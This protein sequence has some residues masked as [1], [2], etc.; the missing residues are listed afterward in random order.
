MMCHGQLLN[1]A[2]RRARKEHHCDEC[3]S[4]IPKGREYNAQAIA[5]EGSI[6]NVKL[7]LYCS[8][9]STEFSEAGE[10]YTA[11]WT[12]DSLYDA[13]RFDGWKSLRARLRASMSRIRERFRK[14]AVS[15]AVK[16]E[17]RG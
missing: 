13:A 7:C 11:G 4:P 12:R 1:D 5:F 15:D 9:A 8:A 6:D 17:K 16:G 10:C 3:G 14:P 2:L